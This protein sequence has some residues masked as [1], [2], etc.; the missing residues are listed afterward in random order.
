M[1]QEISCNPTLGEE[2]N[3][4]NFELNRNDRLSNTSTIPLTPS[5]FEALI[6]VWLQSLGHV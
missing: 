6:E 4:W 3:L 5:F 1:Q 2:G